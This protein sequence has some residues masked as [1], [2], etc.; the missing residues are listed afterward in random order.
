MRNSLLI[1]FIVISLLY[2]LFAFLVAKYLNILS[3]IRIRK[4]IKQN[5]RITVGSFRFFPLPLRRMRYETF[6]MFCVGNF[7]K[8]CG[9]PFSISVERYCNKFIITSIIYIE[10]QTKYLQIFNI[11]FSQYE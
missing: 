2:A 5:Y 1:D 11:F 6:E 3:I 8:F 9:S 7:Y 4:T 10:L